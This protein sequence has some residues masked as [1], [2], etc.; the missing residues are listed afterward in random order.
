MKRANFTESQIV[1]ILKEQKQ[2]KS[3]ADICRKHGISRPTLNQWKS[4]S[5][6]NV[7]QLTQVEEL[8][9]KLIQFKKVAAEQTLNI[10]VLK[11]IL[12][13]EL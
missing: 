10:T 1:G 9:A 7:N 11:D 8:E 5:V 12:E 3:E 4:K 2:G 13:K 6:M